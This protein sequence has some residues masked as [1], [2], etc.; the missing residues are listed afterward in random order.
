MAVEI[1][2]QGS[3][4]TR[5][6]K[7]W[8]NSITYTGPEAELK[9]F[10]ASLRIGGTLEGLNGAISNIDISQGSGPF[11]NCVVKGTLNF[12]DDGNQSNP[13]N[14]TGPNSQRLHG[15]MKS[16]PVENHPNDRTNWNHYL[17]GL[18]N[19]SQTVPSWWNT[20]TT[21]WLDP[22]KT[23]EKNY[24]WVK[25]IG[26]IPRQGENVNGTTEYWRVC[27]VNNVQCVPRVAMSSYDWVVYTITETGKHTSKNRA[28]WVAAEALNSIV[29]RP[30]LGDFGLTSK[31]GGD[32]KVDD[33]EVHYDGQYWVASRTYTKSANANG[34]NQYF[35]GQVKP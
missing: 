23:D 10:A 25:S 15:T 18:G 6:G 4:E 27:S 1:K 7:S 22:Q 32:W 14:A 16:S 21:T 17:I 20:K 29:S 34:W 9:A 19:A 2:Y 35:Y 30:S 3:S 13:D 5:N 33:V 12:D 28:G 26:D 8:T 11:W 24:R 31:L